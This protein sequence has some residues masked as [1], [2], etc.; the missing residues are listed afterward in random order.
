MSIASIN[1]ATGQTIRRFEQLTTA[2]IDARLTKAWRAAVV[3]R[4]TPLAERTAV[5]RRMGDLLLKDRDR[6]AAL[7]TTEMGKPIKAARDEATKCADACHYFADH[8]VEFLAPEEVAMKGERA[9]VEFHPIGP[10]LA[11]MPWNFPFWQVIRFAA[12]ALCAGNVGVLKHA[13]NVPQCSLALEE[14]AT[15]AGAPSGVFQSLL[16]GSEV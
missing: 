10:V 11:V 5:V 1:P 6:Y 7:M 2:A 15:L 16:V 14:L 3:W 12:P 9:W 13:S 4:T 8:A